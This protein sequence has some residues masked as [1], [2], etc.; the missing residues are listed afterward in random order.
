MTTTDERPDMAEL[1]QGGAM[2]PMHGLTE[3]THIGKDD[4]PFVDL[5]DGSSIQL[6]QADLN[7]GLWVI[8]SR[9]APGYSVPKHYHTGSVFAV[10]H[11]GSWYYKEYP[12]YVNRAGSYLYEPAHSVHTL[13]V[14][15]DN[16]GDTEVWFA[17]YGANINMTEEGQVTG[18]V[19]A[20]GILGIYRAVCEQQGLSHEKVI[21][22]GEPE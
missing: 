1:L 18:V 11:S 7:Q 13:M 9:F 4:L 12:E 15:Q 6:L 21:V 22:I 19:D 5:G 2:L 20:Q 10:T 16:E 8:N 3:A 17:I 14:S